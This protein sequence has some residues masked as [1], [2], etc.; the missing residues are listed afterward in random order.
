MQCSTASVV[1]I[2]GTYGSSVGSLFKFLRWIFF[3]NVVLFVV[4]FLFV[5][6][7]QAVH[8]DYSTVNASFSIT[9]LLDAT[10]SNEKPSCR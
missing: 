6:I 5:L 1:R 9:D 8:F 2:K 10:V 4:W 3:L 7:P